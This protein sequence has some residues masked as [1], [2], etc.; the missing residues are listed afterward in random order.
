MCV[1]VCVFGRVANSPI[2]LDKTYLCVRECE[3]VCACAC[4]CMCVYVC[5]CLFVCVCE[6]ESIYIYIYTYVYIYI[7]IYM[8]TYT[9]KFIY[10]CIHIFMRLRE[11]RER[12]EYSRDARYVEDSLR[13][14]TK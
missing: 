2:Q 13:I 14:A 10:R 5:V 3:F 8:Y 4:V 1:C 12:V 6:R 9:H 11:E 7:Y